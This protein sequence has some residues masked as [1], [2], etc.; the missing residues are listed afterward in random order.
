LRDF[1]EQIKAI[2]ESQ[3]VILGYLQVNEN[4]PGMEKKFKLEKI[5][6]VDGQKLFVENMEALNEL[7][8]KLKDEDFF[9][10]AV[11]LLIVKMCLSFIR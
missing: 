11:S 1:K 7:E 8:N 3:E 2:K 10:R 5:G 9:Q 4:R 6:F